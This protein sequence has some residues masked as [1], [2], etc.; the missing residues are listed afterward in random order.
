MFHRLSLLQF[1]T[2]YYTQWP[3]S[4]YVNNSCIRVMS[5]PAEQ[6]REETEQREGT[7]DSWKRWGQAMGVGCNEPGSSSNCF[8]SSGSGQVRFSS[9]DKPEL[10]QINKQAIISDLP[11]SLLGLWPFLVWIY[12]K[13]SYSIFAIFHS[14]T[15]YHLCIYP[16]LKSWENQY[17]FPITAFSI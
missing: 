2:Y 1:N 5:W 7:R 17:C 6:G 13:C 8:K 3:K 11:G 9:L 15:H 4:C 16:T 12:E 14:I 10:I